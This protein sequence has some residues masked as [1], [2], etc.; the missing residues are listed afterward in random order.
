MV[1]PTTTTLANGNHF[2]S[3]H[4]MLSTHVIGLSLLGNSAGDQ[5]FIVKLSTALLY[6]I[7]LYCIVLYCIAFYSILFYSILFYSILFYSILFCFFAPRV[8][9]NVIP[10]LNWN[11]RLD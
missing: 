10:D 3:S 4:L 7:V 6:C 2:I 1:S 9:T 8:F 5:Y 11:V